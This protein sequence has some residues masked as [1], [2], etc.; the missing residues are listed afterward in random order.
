MAI[1]CKSEREWLSVLAMHQ[2]WDT[3]DRVYLGPV[4]MVAGIGFSPLPRDPDKGKWKSMNGWRT[5]DASWVRSL[6]NLKTSSHP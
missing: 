4:A 5:E 3:L 6:K 1:R 2:I